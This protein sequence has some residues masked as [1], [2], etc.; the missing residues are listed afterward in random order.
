MEQRAK[1]CGT[2]FDRAVFAEYPVCV[3]TNGGPM[4]IQGYYAVRGASGLGKEISLRRRALELES[5]HNEENGEKSQRKSKK[6][7][8][9]SRGEKERERSTGNE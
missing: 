1:T 9:S 3:Y 8:K 5:W 6:I 7:I 2:R 4:Q